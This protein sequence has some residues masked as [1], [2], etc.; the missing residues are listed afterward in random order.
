MDNRHDQ[1]PISVVEDLDPE[2][3]GSERT[4]RLGELVLGLVLLFGVLAWGGWQWWRDTTMQEAYRQGSVAAERRDWDAARDAFRSASGYRDADTRAQD[5][6]R[7]ASERDSLYASA[8]GAMNEDRP[9]E[10]LR[11]TTQL[12]T[13]QPDYRDVESLHERALL[14][15]IDNALVGVGVSGQTAVTGLRPGLYAGLESGRVRL[16]GSDWNSVVRAGAL[17]GPEG[18]AMYDAPS[19]G[20]RSLRLACVEGDG[21]R[22]EP[23]DAGFQPDDFD[24]YVSGRRGGWGLSVAAAATPIYQGTDTQEIERRQRLQG[25][26]LGYDVTYLPAGS[27]AIP[28]S[29]AD[30]KWIV[31]GLGDQG[32]LLL[33]APVWGGPGGGMGLYLERPDGSPPR[34]LHEQEG[35]FIAAHLGPGERYALLTSY[36]P[37]P[38]GNTGEEH[39]LLLVDTA[40]GAKTVLASGTSYSE[41]E[42]PAPHVG[43]AFIRGGPLDGKVVAARW[44]YEGSI[45]LID[46]ERPDE[47]LAGLPVS[48]YPGSQ[49][50]A[51]GSP[52]GLAVV[53]W[54]APNGIGRGPSSVN[55]AVLRPGRESMLLNGPLPEGET[56]WGVAQR[57]DNALYITR[58]TGYP[59][60]RRGPVH[61][62]GLHAPEG[63]EP[64]EARVLYSEPPYDWSQMSARAVRPALS[65]HLGE[66]GVTYAQDG[67]LYVAP[68]DGSPPV[69]LAPGMEPLPFSGASR[70]EW[71]R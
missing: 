59:T 69:M 14:T 41:R 30:S 54:Q 11:A 24:R 13:I 17:N 9:V 50:Y 51:A 45:T 20:G 8:T 56:L 4:R 5:A 28:Y 63:S 29:M 31:M 57:G 6:A 2:P 52:E 62:R 23:L 10:A 18:C 66:E 65:W 25:A 35:G 55:V 48:G 26:L 71:V 22:T 67:L 70:S 33:I 53:G 42:D 61:V 15:A 64:S 34:L 46:P 38:G 60:N 21:V 19:P 49:V 3:Q 7:L 16:E 36:M 32:G 58:R 40:T 27:R 43:G 37:L 1:D 44:A 39:R 68:F 12:R 47:P